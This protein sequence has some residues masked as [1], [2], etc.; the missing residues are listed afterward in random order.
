MNNKCLSQLCHATSSLNP[1]F[2]L[3][4]LYCATT[5]ALDE[6]PDSGSSYES[7]LHMERRSSPYDY[8]LGKVIITAI[9]YYLDGVGKFVRPW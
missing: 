5:F 9:N 6:Y 8:F 3:Q 4:A 7:Q 1:F 2:V